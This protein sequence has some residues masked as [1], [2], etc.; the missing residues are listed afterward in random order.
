MQNEVEILLDELIYYSINAIKLMKPS[1]V[2][3]IPDAA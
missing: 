2:S 3:V 1:I